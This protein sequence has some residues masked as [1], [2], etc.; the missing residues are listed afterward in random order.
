M[1]VLNVKH[2]A[3]IQW[4][5]SSM[6]SWTARNMRTTWIWVRKI[7]MT[8]LSPANYGNFCVSSFREES[9]GR[10]QC[11]RGHQKQQDKQL[12]VVQGHWTHESLQAEHTQ[13]SIERK[14]ISAFHS[15][16]RQA[17]AVLLD[18]DCTR[19]SECTM[20]GHWAQQSARLAQRLFQ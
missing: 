19:L 18:R 12:K 9:W 11:H 6:A 10:R 15:A 14:A 13:V 5:R 7:R 4:P 3:T 8:L 2:A 20:R 16:P 1:N 17:S